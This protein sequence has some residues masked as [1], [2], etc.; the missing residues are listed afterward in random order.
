MA[1]RNL[2]AG[3]R[4]VYGNSFVDAAKAIGSG[5]QGY[6][7]GISPSTLANL[8]SMKQTDAQ[9]KAYMEGLNTEMDLLDLSTAEQ[10]S[11]KGYL[12]DQK[13]R[14]AQLA[15]ELA[16]TDAMGGRYLELKNEMDGIKQ[17][18]LNLKNQTDKFKERKIQYLDDLENGRLSKGNKTE[19]YNT[20]GSVYGGGALLIDPN[21]G[22]NVVTD[23][24]KG[25][26]RYADV[27]DPF[28][29]DFKTA[30]EIL[31]QNNKLYNAGVALDASKEALLRNQLKSKL[32]QDGSLESIVEDGLINNERL[33]VDLDA[34]ET[35]EDAINDVAEILLQ[36]YR[37]SAAAGAE[38][39]RIRKG[40]NKPTDT[41]GSLTNP[42]GTY[43]GYG[44]NSEQDKVNFEKN[45]NA[46]QSTA[47]RS[48]EIMNK[49]AKKASNPIEYYRSWAPGS[50]I[51]G[52][53]GKLTEPPRE[54]QV[55][56]QKWYSSYDSKK[57]SGEAKTNQRWQLAPAIKWTKDGYI[58]VTIWRR[59]SESD[60]QVLTE[61]DYKKEF[62]GTAGV[63][64]NNTSTS[65]G[66]AGR[67]SPNQSN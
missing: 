58:P 21:G 2:I 1:N 57:Y 22:I 12:F 16:Q 65:P 60:W 59:N 52:K 8:A 19:D 41:K 40:K 67:F 55:Y 11:V 36:G 4:A 6:G 47:A 13:Q 48:A 39:K 3:T 49:D 44:R 10:N 64:Q 27:K 32:S 17:S 26:V 50:A 30:D 38:E 61:E 14:Y 46:T 29:K 25:L 54:R 42:D 9:V 23:G 62:N 7:S 34:Y 5:M 18:F 53:N 31:E 63:T 37:D 15:T 28:L 33:N 20:A 56:V 45:W 51:F 35:R 24:G 43:L 66:G